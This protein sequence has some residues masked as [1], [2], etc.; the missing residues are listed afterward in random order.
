MRNVNLPKI[1]VVLL[2]LAMLIATAIMA[3]AEPTQDELDAFKS[4]MGLYMQS[5]SVGSGESPTPEE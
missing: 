2:T 1:T 4:A 3:Y 5:N